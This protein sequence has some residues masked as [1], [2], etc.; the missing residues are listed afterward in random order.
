MYYLR[1]RLVDPLGIEPSGVEDPV[2]VAFF[3][4]RAAHMV[5][6]T[7]IELASIGPSNLTGPLD[8]ARGSRTPA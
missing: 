3:L 8:P 6:R 1:G 2:S 7:R 4:P 5:D